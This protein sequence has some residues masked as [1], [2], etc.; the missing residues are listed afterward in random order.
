VD[1]ILNGN[2]FR[3]EQA[4]CRA[5]TFRGLT[6]EHDCDGAPL[7]E[8]G[9]DPGHGVRR[10]GRT[11]Q[12]LS[13][14]LRGEGTFFTAATHGMKITIAALGKVFFHRPQ[15][16]WFAAVTFMGM[17]KIAKIFFARP[18]KFCRVLPL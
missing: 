17:R 14:C 13:R 10:C 12:W 15:V 2:T 7:L 18:L 11:L 1:A 8:D 3:V 4:G 5:A 6:V 16:R 9:R